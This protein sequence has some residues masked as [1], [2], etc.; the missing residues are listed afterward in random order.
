MTLPPVPRVQSSPP[1][2]CF[3]LPALARLCSH[4]PQPRCTSQASSKQSALVDLSQLSPPQT[5]DSRIPRWAGAGRLAGGQGALSQSLVSAHGGWR[6]QEG[7]THPCKGLRE[8]QFPHGEGRE[9]CHDIPAE[10]CCGCWAMP[11]PCFGGSGL[12]A[13]AL[14]LSVSALGTTA[15]QPAPPPPQPT[16]SQ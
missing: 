5:A 9:A 10:T 16:S 4:C 15:A 1:H 6:G 14:P 11:G 7:S 2:A 3:P 8:S 13:L 12:E